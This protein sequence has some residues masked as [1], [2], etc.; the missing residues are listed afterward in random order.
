MAALT[1]YTVANAVLALV[2][3][4]VQVYT[5]PRTG[6]LAYVGHVCNFRQK[7]SKFLASLPLP[8]DEFPFVMVRPRKF[9]NRP[10]GKAPFKVNVQKLRSAFA[11]LKMN[12][13]YYYNVEW[14]DAREAEWVDEDIPVGSTREE[15][16]MQA[17]ASQCKRV[18]GMDAACAGPSRI[19]REQVA[20][21]TTVIDFVGRAARGRG[22]RS[23]ESD[24]IVGGRSCWKA[25][26]A[27]SPEFA[28]AD[29]RHSP[30]G[31]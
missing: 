17:L 10:S 21:M 6:Q 2:H 29:V 19:C 18:R 23:L 5:I 31:S 28:R 25:V 22:S 3:P 27:S 4:L 13:P 14:V 11:W 9:H 8:K 15:D 24:A 20:H 30:A 7:L 26:V 16:V 12:N 1:V